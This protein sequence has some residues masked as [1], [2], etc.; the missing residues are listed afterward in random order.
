[1]RLISTATM[2][3]AVILLCFVALRRTPT[4]VSEAEAASLIGGCTHIAAKKN[5]KP[6]GSSC[7]NIDGYI[8]IEVPVEGNVDPSGLEI[9]IGKSCTSINSS[10]VDCSEP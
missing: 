3:V 7:P 4:V 1:M 9:C 8:F 2:I 10:Y 5:C 6:D